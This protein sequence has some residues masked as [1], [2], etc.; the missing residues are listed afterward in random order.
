VTCGA[1]SGRTIPT[2][3]GKIFIEQLNVKGSVLGTLQ[4]FRDLISL[5]VA[6]SIEP[7]IG[8]VLPIDEAEIGFRKMLDGETEGKIV[9]TI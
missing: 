9:V 2:D 8:L 1:H 6:K 4:E 3:V 7:H 5:V